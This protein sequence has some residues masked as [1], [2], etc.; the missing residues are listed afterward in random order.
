MKNQS[1]AQAEATAEVPIYR[2][3]PRDHLRRGLQKSQKFS[4]IFKRFTLFFEYFQ[5]FRTIFRKFSNVF[6]RF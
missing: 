6:K 4:N 3:A 1:N 2:E 5:K